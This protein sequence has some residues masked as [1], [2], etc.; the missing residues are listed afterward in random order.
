MTSVAIMQPTFLPWLGY[1]ALIDS[2]DHFVF[3][4]D[5]QM[6]KQSWQTRNRIKG[7]NGPIMLSLGVARKPSKPLICEAKLAET[8]F[9]AALLK[10]VSANLGRAPHF[11]VVE[12]ILKRSFE[13]SGAT[14]ASLNIA[15]IDK[16]AEVSG[17]S[18]PRY[19]S[20]DMKVQSTG[21][22]SGRLIEICE[23]FK[24]D[25]YLSPVGA[26]DY[27]TEEGEFDDSATALRFLNYDHPIHPQF[28]GAF[29]SH[30]AAI[31]ALAHVGPD[32]FLDLVRSG[33]KPA[34]SADEV[35]TS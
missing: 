13:T 6:S 14:V 17:I 28:F 31:D 27:L 2:V 19:R 15:I 25:T 32:A 16:I 5:V 35:A 26:H 34:L 12:D 22:R 23:Y 21:T 11:D 20:S 1:F 7:P 30:M 33:I 10:T 9:E 4:D 8:G 18:T 24:A 29:E 3:L